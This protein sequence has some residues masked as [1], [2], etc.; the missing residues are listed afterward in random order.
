MLMSLWKICIFNYRAQAFYSQHKSVRI[1]AIKSYHAYHNIDIISSKRV[2]VRKRYRDDEEPL[3]ARDVRK[4]WLGCNN[5]RLDSSLLI[6]T[7]TGLR[8]TGSLFLLN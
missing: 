5:R 3:Y 1:A 7:D 8:A 4:I 2:K 6:L